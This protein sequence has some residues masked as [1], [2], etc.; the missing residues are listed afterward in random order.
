MMCA[1]AAQ[2][3]C[4]ALFQNPHSLA[5]GSRCTHMLTCVSCPVGC[6][7][8]AV[9]QEASRLV[10]CRDSPLN[11]VLGGAA[12]GALLF[13]SHGELGG[14]LLS[15]AAAA[16]INEGAVIWD[17]CC[18]PA[19]GCSNLPRHSCRLNLCLQGSQARAVPSFAPPLAVWRT[20]LPRG[21]RQRGACSSCS[22][23]WTCWTRPH[24]HHLAAQ[25]QRLPRLLLRR[26]QQQQRRQRQRSSRPSRR[27]RG[28]TSTCRCG[29]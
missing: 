21:L 26:R 16:G 1:L 20:S 28:G 6:L 5:A 8:A 23:Q 27:G 12:T 29:A 10:R 4:F 11:S 3:C 22:S 13:K 14:W 25:R 9:V 17:G 7:A 18:L 2:P 24:R 15:G 19:L